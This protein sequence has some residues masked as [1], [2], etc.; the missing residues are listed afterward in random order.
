MAGLPPPLRLGIEQVV[1]SCTFD[2]FGDAEA[3]DKTI[4]DTVASE[5]AKLTEYP[6]VVRTDLVPAKERL[7][8]EQNKEL[9]LQVAARIEALADGQRQLTISVQPKRTGIRGQRAAAAVTVTLTSESGSAELSKAASEALAP[10]LSP[11]LPRIRPLR[12][13]RLPEPP[14]AD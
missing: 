7:L 6:V 5:A 13:A 2:G 12:R 11:A 1:I 10:I 3:L 9:V 4:C 14:R 8:R